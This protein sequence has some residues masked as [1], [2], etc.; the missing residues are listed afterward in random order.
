MKFIAPHAHQDTLVRPLALL[1]CLVLLDSGLQY[2][3][4]QRALDVLPVNSL[5]KQVSST[6]TSVKED[7]PLENIQQRSDSLLM[8]SVLDARLVDSLL[9]QVSL[10]TTSVK[11]DAPLENIQQRLDSLLIISVLNVLQVSS[12]LRREN[13]PATLAKNALLTLTPAT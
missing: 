11:E 12:L 5:L 4:K 2:L 9:K 8:I 10:T 6:T 1:V 7:A 3:H 13:Q